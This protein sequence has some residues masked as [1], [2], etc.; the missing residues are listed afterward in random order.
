MKIVFYNKNLLSGGIEKCIEL[1][2]KNIY[3]DFDID[4]VYTHTDKLDPNIVE[5]LKRY[6][7]VY[8]LEDKVVECD[9]A[10]WCFLYFDYRVVKQQIKAKKNICWI[11]SMPRILP[12]CLLDNEEFVNDMDEF[13]CVS[14]AVKRNLNIKKEGKVI[15]NFMPNDI[16]ELSNINP[17][18]YQTE[19]L[20][21]VVVSRLS[22]GKGFE[23]LLIMT[24]TL[25]NK[26]IPFKITVIGKGRS[27]E[28]RIRA[29]FAP[30]SNVEFVGYQE[31]PYR[32]IKNADYLVQLSDAESWCN[33]IT[34][35]KILGV[36]VIVTNFES[37][38]E[39][40]VHLENGILIPLEETDYNSYIELACTYKE[41]LKENLKNFVFENEMELWYK[42]FE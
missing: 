20:N 33:V 3:K 32:Y 1:L 2:S 14:E 26:G 35:A 38:K 34:E 36:P 42:L 5:V 11:H 13:I 41:A 27:E 7:N 10:I 22:T 37:A 15:H 24:E 19:C 28:E 18:Q 30:Y 23:R 40:V 39:Q 21:L 16:V 4:V 6:A 8:Q 9:V 31:N 25:I 29:S 12:D 17:I